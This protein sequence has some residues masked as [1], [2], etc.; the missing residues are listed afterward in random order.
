MI[1]GIERIVF[2]V[3]AI[4]AILL[5]LK[6][7]FRLF[8]ILCLGRWENRFDY[9]WKRTGFLLKYGFGQVRVMARKFG[10][11]HFFIFWSFL[12]LMIVYIEFLIHGIFPKFSF[13]FLGHIPYGIITAMADIM[14]LVA[15]TCVCIAMIRRTFFRAPYLSVNFEAYFIPSLIAVL[16]IAYFVS[17]STAYSV[18][19]PVM[20][21][22]LP[23]TSKLS[24]FWQGMD[25]HTLHIIS[26]VAWWVHALILFFF[27]NY[28][29]YSK[30]LHI[31]ASLPNCFFR[32]DT[33]TATVPR[34]VFRKGER[35]GIAKAV[36]FTWKDILDF[37]AC[38]E[39]GRC[40]DV[41][42][43]A[44]TGKVL[45]PKELIHQCKVNTFI[46]GDAI[47]ASRPADM[48]AP[49]PDDATEVVPL[50]NGTDKSVSREAL[51]DCTTC[52]ACMQVCPVFIEHVPKIIQMRQ[53]L[54]MEKAEFPHELITF[55]EASEQRFNPWGMAP[56]DRTKWTMGMKVPLMAEV[57]EAEYLFFVG[58]AGAFDSRVRRST[59]A[60]VN[61]L[62]HAG[63]S[64]AIL[65][66]EEKCCGDS[67]RRL[68]NEYVFNQLVTDNINTFKKYGV[69]KIV[70][71]CPHCYNT[72]KND[73]RQYGLSVEV[74]HHSQLI[75]TLL[76]EGRIV[77][78]KP[79]SEKVVFH[80]SCYLG[81]YNKVYEEPRQVLASCTTRHFTEMK[82][83][84]E[85]SFCCG[86]GGGRMW[87]EEVSGKRIYLERTHQAMATGASLI[88][89]SCPYC[90]TMFEDG[91]KDEKATGKIQVKDIAEIV[92]GSI[93]GLS[94]GK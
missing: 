26:K 11:N 13:E 68:G 44:N 91:L 87:M 57:K 71:Q 81:R 64:W 48:L 79:L 93:N 7:V 8:A 15:L 80:D 3:V 18:H 25:A 59:L 32:N 47:R 43:A 16:M 94:P 5:F 24:L 84:R 30:H 51:W 61:I 37:M 72:L 55:F 1:T 17:G 29:P 23:V 6:N 45:N 39:C 33:L 14:S 19:P 41:C 31:L 40:Q 66:N 82:K 46:N 20:A 75:S 35:F 52:G 73:Y 27:L 58:C 9:L 28:L 53:H 70:T 21:A 92:A 83:N 34:L 85:N 63:V 88:A 22:W 49:A 78:D 60:F 12:T 54:V 56:S 69:K 2:T 67:Q 65:G 76:K 86:A 74:I 4:S 42:P 38:T 90:M 62:N 77:P 50:I 36:Q 89:V 10:I